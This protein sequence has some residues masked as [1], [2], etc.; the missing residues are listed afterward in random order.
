M[1]ADARRRH[2]DAAQRQRQAMAHYK[3]QYRQQQQAQ[4]AYEQASAAATAASY[5]E[6]VQALVSLHQTAIAPIQWHAQ[7]TCSPPTAPPFLRHHEAGA[8][9]ALQGFKPKFLDRALGKVAARRSALEVEVEQAKARDVAAYEEAK[10]KH[11]GAH[12]EWAGRA[13]FAKTVLAR[14]VRVYR[15]VLEAF[16][17]H[18]TFEGLGAAVRVDAVQPDLVAYTTMVD[19]GVV[20]K[21]EI[22]LT[23]KAK[24][25]EKPLATGKYWVLFQDHICSCALRLARDAFAM[26]PVDRV[27]VNIGGATLNSTTGHRE[28]VTMLAAHITRPALERINLDAI[29]PSDSMTNFQHRM[30]FKKTKGFDTVEPITADEQW[31][32]T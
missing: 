7:A 14:D 32:T 12:A 6:Y 22:K 28:L 30:K 31:V 24:I 11:A 29:D 15:E 26:L 1:E 20:P 21:L 2:K 23:A 13:A 19:E 17:V 9:A 8:V 5:E 10:R 3:A 25:T 4:R 18:A 16:G 27:I